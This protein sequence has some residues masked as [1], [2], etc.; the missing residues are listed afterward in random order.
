MIELTVTCCPEYELPSAKVTVRCDPEYVEVDLKVKTEYWDPDMTAEEYEKEVAGYVLPG[1]AWRSALRAAAA[2]VADHLRTKT[3][4][5]AAD[6]EPVADDDMAV[7]AAELAK[8][9]SRRRDPETAVVLRVL[10]RL[11]GSAG[12]D[13]ALCPEGGLSKSEFAERLH[14][15]FPPTGYSVCPPP[16][17]GCGTGGAPEYRF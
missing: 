13:D 14:A 5:A 15:R 12:A 11:R 6:A 10:G 16:A 2:T 17:G 3:A 7:L 8:L 9:D 1:G 4:S